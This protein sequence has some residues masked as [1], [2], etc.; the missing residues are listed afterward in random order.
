MALTRDQ[1]KVQVTELTDDFKSAQSVIFA[2]YIGLDVAEISELRKTLRAQDAKMRVAKKTLIRIA[3]KEA[4]MPEIEDNVIDGPISCIFSFADPLTGAQIAFKFAKNHEQVVLIGGIF[5]GKILTTEEALELAKMP[6]RQELLAM[7]AGMLRSPL[8]TFASMCSS[9]LSSFARGVKEMAAKGDA[10]QP[11]GEAEEVKD[12][13][14][15]ETKET[16]ETED[17]SPKSDSK[18]SNSEE[19]TA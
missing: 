8:I 11:S 4:G 9:P 13:K 12:V 1:K 18:S 16:E 15:E 17:S 2:H 14:K 7:F 5:D 6:G 10:T 3:A 19:P